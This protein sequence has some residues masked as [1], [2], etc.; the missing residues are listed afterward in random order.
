M[1]GLNELRAFTKAAAAILAREKDL[2]AY[3]VYC[4]TSE[5]RVA[6]LNYTSDIPSRGIEEFKSL[7]ADGF[8]VRLVTREEPCE[9]GSASIAG[10][11]SPAAVREAIARSRRA[12]FIDPH[13]PGLPAE[14]RRL[15]K[16]AVEE[17]A[18]RELLN[19][20]DA[21]LAAAA[22]QII[23]GAIV[24]FERRAPLKLA[25]PGLVLGGD[26]SLIR[27]RIVL[28]NSS[29][30]D[31]RTDENAHFV[32][33]VTVLIEAFEA[34]GTTMSVGDTIAA[35]RN[36]SA[37]LGRD[38][39]IRA[40]ELR[41]GEHPDPGEYRVLL[42]PQPLAEILNYIVIPSLTAGAFHAANSAYY[43]RFGAEITD[44]RL[45]L[46][47]D[48]MARQSPIRRHITCEGLPA[49]R[50]DL[51]RDGRLVGLLSTFYDTHRLLNDEHRDEK[52]GAGAAGMKLEFPPRSGYR[53]GD[54]AARR[55]DA[56]PG[57]AGTSVIMRARDG[58]DDS[59]LL[60]AV[61]DGIYAGRV[62]YTYPINGQ[63][64]GDFTCTISGDSHI[65]RNGKIAAPLA[66][67]C[68]RINANIAQVFSHPL[69][70]GRKTE[71]AVVWGA[72]EVYFVCPIAAK[73]ITLAAIG[74]SES[75]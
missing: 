56:H 43:G 68:L 11:L 66:P 36:A 13:S 3:E 61:G 52:L 70:V 72:P 9:S 33:S 29:F 64:A 21:V 57:A 67:N 19:L 12:L 6:R 27:D 20:N 4:S 65:I 59:N 16:P 8:T 28:C 32:A 69:E 15:P 22:W 23:G 42:G 25:Y 14:P 75:E 18:S 51:I 58:A 5:H 17:N 34:K 37:R 40:L 10:D 60:A 38:A 47:D 7:N 39:V 62:W 49:G 54:G 71:A 74:A 53:L 2:V 26:L 24:E 41:H 44:P 46:S 1:R 45:S 30:E 35:I 73:D 48:P 31:L 50:T 55:F 63:R